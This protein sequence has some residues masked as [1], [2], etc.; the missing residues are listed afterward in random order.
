MPSARWMCLAGPQAALTVTSGLTWACSGGPVCAADT[1]RGL[2][3]GNN[4]L[5]WAYRLAWEDAWVA[6]ALAAGVDA[7]LSKTAH[8]ASLG[9]L[10]REIVN[11]SHRE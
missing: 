5:T 8:L 6:Q 2:G 3:G 10:I 7:C 11:H 1:R 4:P 9:T